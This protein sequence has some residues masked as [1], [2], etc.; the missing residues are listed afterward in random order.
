[1][2]ENPD[3]GFLVKET[4]A[5]PGLVV[6]RLPYGET[7]SG[8][9]RHIP[10]APVSAHLSGISLTHSNACERKLGMSFYITYTSTSHGRQTGSQPCVTESPFQYSVGNESPVPVPHQSWVPPAEKD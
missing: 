2:R 9:C 8:S 4:Q 5:T 1:M 3:L 6:T 10:V 7:V